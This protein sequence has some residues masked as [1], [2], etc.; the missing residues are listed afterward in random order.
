MNYLNMEKKGWEFLDQ[1][2]DLVCEKY[3]MEVAI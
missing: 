2:N 3:S 1:M